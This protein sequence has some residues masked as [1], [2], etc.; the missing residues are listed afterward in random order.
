MDVSCG[1]IKEKQGST[2][3]AAVVSYGSGGGK[4]FSAMKKRIRCGGYS[5]EEG[6]KT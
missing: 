4:S 6:K 5:D 3:A 2:H 1:C